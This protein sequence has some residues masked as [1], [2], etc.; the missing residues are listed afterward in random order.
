MTVA[1]KYCGGCNPRYERTELAERLR[2]D[3]PG[4]RIV[5]A[6]EPADVAAIICGCP[7]ACASRA[8]LTARLGAVVLTSPADYD[9]L[10]RP[11]LA[12]QSDKE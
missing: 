10:L 4:V 8:G 7:A 3:F 11:L 9:R 1:V 12:A 2:A 6:E 5:R